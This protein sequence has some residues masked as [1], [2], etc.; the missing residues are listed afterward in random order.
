[1]KNIPAAIRTIRTAAMPPRILCLRV[2]NPPLIS[3][4]LAK[5]RQPDRSDPGT[6][7]AGRVQARAR[8]E[9]HGEALVDIAQADAFAIDELRW[10]HRV[11]DAQ[12]ELV[13]LR[14]DVYADR[15]RAFMA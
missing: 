12:N 13:T 8:A 4:A 14:L 5:Q 11:R 1:M 15:D 7:V 2:M 9:L 6:G 10:R 3:R